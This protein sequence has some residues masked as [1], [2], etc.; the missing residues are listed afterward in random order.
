MNVLGSKLINSVELTYIGKMAEA[1][2]N[3]A[4]FLESPVGVGE[5][6]S[7]T[8]EIKTLLLE[9]AEAK[10]VIQ[11]IGEIK[12]NGKVDKFFKEE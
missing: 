4:V 6:S 1:K 7:I 3:L 10:D 9:L 11:V 2:A 12:A 5:H 8:E